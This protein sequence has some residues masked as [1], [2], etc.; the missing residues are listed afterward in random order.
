MS[1]SEKLQD[2]LAYPPRL[3]AADRAASYVRFGSTKFLEMVDDGRMLKPVDV[4]GSKRWDRF[5][6]DD[7][8]DNLKDR[9]RDPVMRDRDRLQER[10]NA[11]EG[12]G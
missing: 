9:R 6:L 3:L 11:M 7:A 10:I 2:H 4:D 1:A 8:V 12:K 5:E